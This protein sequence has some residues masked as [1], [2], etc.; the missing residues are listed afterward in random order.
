MFYEFYLPFPPSVN[1]YYVH[2]RNG[3]FISKKGK[4]YRQAVAEA[5]EEQM[6]GVHITDR[7]FIECVLFPPDRRK[8][9]LGNYD[10]AMM[11]AITHAG[12]WED[13]EL[14]DQQMFYRGEV[15]KP[16]Q[17][18]VRVAEAGPV[19]KAGQTPP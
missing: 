11:D 8:R 3:M 18:F 12:F 10:K 13:D 14:I 9:D 5:I 4:T 2:T 6:A 19:L 16:G 7:I 1:N 17:V 15:C